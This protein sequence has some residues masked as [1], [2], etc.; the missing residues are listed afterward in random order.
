MAEMNIHRSPKPIKEMITMSKMMNKGCVTIMLVIIRMTAAKADIAV[1]H[2]HVNSKLN[3]TLALTVGLA[4]CL[5]NKSYMR[6]TFVDWPDVISAPN[7]IT[8]N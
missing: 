3:P 1:N 2:S 4:P 5:R 7:A 8:T 6:A